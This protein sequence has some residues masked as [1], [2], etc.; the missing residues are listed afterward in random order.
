M[1]CPTEYCVRNTSISTY[2][3][4]FSTNSDYDGYPSWSGSSNGYFIYFKTGT[5]QWCLS[6]T[7]GGNCL[8][9]GKSPCTSE[10]PD[11]FNVYLSSGTCP[12][13][14][15]TPTNNCSVLDFDSF[16][17]CS[18]ID[19]ITPTP[20][21]TPTS[22]Q[23]PTPTSTNVCGIIKV[24]AEINNV[25]STPTPT[26]TQTP[27]PSSQVIRDCPFSGN[28]TF[29]TI[30]VS[31]NCPVS[32]KF[33]DC[34]NPNLNYTTTDVLVNPSG[35]EITENMIFNADVDGNAKCITYIGIDKDTIGG[36]TILLKAGPLGV[37]TLCEP[38]RTPTQTPSQTPTITPTNT[39]TPTNTPSRTPSQTPTKSVTPTPTKTPT[40]TPTNTPTTNLPISC[41]LSGYTY[42]VSND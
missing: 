19:F 6:N 7:L 25:T 38:T 3:D 41:G 26:P 37:C 30:N 5:T 2:D 36:N 40:P 12:T 34:N 18:T 14:T 22:T 27:T 10:C 31:I 20:T 21:P 42:N 39:Q 13:P 16:F 17:D 8:L 11:F 15:P 9:S 32:K 35:G 1:S 23:T 24:N 33:S 29:N 4:N 28:V